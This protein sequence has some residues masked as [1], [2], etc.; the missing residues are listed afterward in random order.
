[1]PTK[2]GDMLENKTYHI[3][4]IWKKLANVGQ[5]VFAWTFWL[6]FLCCIERLWIEHLVTIVLDPWH[7][8]LHVVSLVV[9]SPITD[10]RRWMVGSLRFK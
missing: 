10:T 9:S 7:T 5:V 6:F 2:K 3:D 4:I 8:Q 1:M